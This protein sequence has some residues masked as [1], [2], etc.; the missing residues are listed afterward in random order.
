M[1]SLQLQLTIATQGAASPIDAAG[2]AAAAPPRAL[3]WFWMLFVAAMILRVLAMILTPLLPE[4]AYYWM[5]AQHPAL[6]YFDHPPMVA[7]V[8]GA[9]TAVFGDN[10]F[11][12]RIVGNLLMIVASGLMYRMARLWY[13]RLTAAISALLLQITPIYF[14]TGFLTTPD[15]PL[16][17]FW[18]TCLLGLATA[19]KQGRASGWY[20]AGLGLGGAMLSK[21][22]GV[23]LGVGTLIALLGHRPWRRQLLTPHPYLASLLALA[24]FSPVVIWNWRHDWASF[25]F[26]S[27]GRFSSRGL[28]PESVL[29]FLIGQLAVMLPVF[30]AAL[31][32]LAA[33]SL[34]RRRRLRLD[35][36]W[37]AFCLSL[38]LLAVMAYQSLR[39]SIHINWTL[40]AYLSL[41]PALVHLIR[42]AARVQHRKKKGLRWSDSAMTMAWAFLAF[43]AI[44]SLYL[45]TLQSRF[46]IPSAF[47]PWDRLAG[48]VERAEDRLRDQ[49]GRVPIVIANDKYRLAS[50]LAFYR[51]PLDNKREATQLVTSQWFLRGEGLGYE[52]WAKPENFLGSDC[53]YIDDKG[54]PLDFVR[55]RFNS[56]EVID[57]PELKALGEY[58]LAVCRGYKGPQ[59]PPK[60]KRQNKPGDDSKD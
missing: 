16:V 18:L 28:S 48:I 43:D 36:T 34:T 46:G 30:L 12:V 26:Q 33:R 23:F 19:L 39:Y 55:K 1:T 54:D 45:F 50:V 31:G 52:Y 7:W 20:L 13:G 8:I 40:P 58:T 60:P 6:S 51:A 47:G 27:S 41:L 10:E 57:D 17:V 2:V 9:G 15:A 21:Y 35:R 38:P 11:G 37:F 5:Y 25:H 22:T 53:I 59:P 3:K 4:E 32:W 44:A 29:T 14:A 49:T 56:V 24:V 42:A